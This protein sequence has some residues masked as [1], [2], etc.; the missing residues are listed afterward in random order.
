[1]KK[2]IALLLL[3]FIL[4]MG[5]VACENEPGTVI[6]TPPE[7]QPEEVGNEGQLL[8]EESQNL[9]EEYSL[10][11]LVKNLSPEDTIVTFLEGLRDLDNDRMRNALPDDEAFI[12]HR[13][14]HIELGISPD[15]LPLIND[16]Q[17]RAVEEFLTILV[18]LLELNQSPLS[19]HD[20]ESLEIIGF[21]PEEYYGEMYLSESNQDALSIRANRWG[22]EQIVSRVVI[23]ELDTERYAWIVDVADFDG[24]WRLVDFHGTLAALFGLHIGLQ[25]IILPEFLDY[26]AS[27]VLGDVEL[28]SIL[29][30]P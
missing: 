1:M 28:D 11:Q 24:D 18:N 10:N 23:F 22:A 21:V 27:E 16:P 19:S 25:G 4:T 8:P 3:I 12:A 30:S 13:E 6:E 2:I 26:L 17:G 15:S 5:V 29:I 14:A 20:F 7:E 9:S